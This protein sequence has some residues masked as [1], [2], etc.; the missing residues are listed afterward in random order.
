[1]Q[2]YELLFILPGTLAEDEVK[3]LVAKVKETV[4]AVGGKEY[5]AEDM[6]KSRLAYPIDHIRYGYFQLAH[7][8]AETK[9]VAAIEKKLRLLNNLL[10]VL[11]Q[12]YDPSKKAQRITFA[13]QISADQPAFVPTPVSLSEENEASLNIQSHTVP[14]KEEKKT[15]KSSAKVSLDD[16]D[17]KLD[18][19]LEIDIDKV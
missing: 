2:N 3:P 13:D 18:E 7:F 15:K 11:I 9:E 8:Q 19:I 1:M 10:R 6:G 12:K 16:I 17:K 5:V 14:V 4:E